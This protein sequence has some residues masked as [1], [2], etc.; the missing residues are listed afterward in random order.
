MKVGSLAGNPLLEQ[1]IADGDLPVRTGMDTEWW[2][3][4]RAIPETGPAAC[5]DGL[6]VWENI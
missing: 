5:D 3:D 4:Y 2:L 6:D 1:V